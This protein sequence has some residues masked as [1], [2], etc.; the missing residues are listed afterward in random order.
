MATTPERDELAT[1]LKATL[2]ARRELGPE[3]DDVLVDSFLE[4]VDRHVREQ[5]NAEAT[6]SRRPLIERPSMAFPTQWLPVLAL[7]VIAVMLLAHVHLFPFF[8]GI[9]FISMGFGRRRGYRGPRQ[10]RTIV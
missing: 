7:V 5:V 8:I 1:E 3:M 4:K 2:A 6:H 10:R 9:F